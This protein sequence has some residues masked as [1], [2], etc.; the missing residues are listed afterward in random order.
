[1]SHRDLSRR[2][3]I[4]YP[5]KYQYLGVQPCEYELIIKDFERKIKALVEKNDEL[6]VKLSEINEEYN[7]INEELKGGLKAIEDR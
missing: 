3:V 6:E 1:M 4:Q 2:R 5:S 7:H